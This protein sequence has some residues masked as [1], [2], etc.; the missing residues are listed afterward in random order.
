MTCERNRAVVN[1]RSRDCESNCRRP[2]RGFT[3]SCSKS[4]GR[5]C[6][7]DSVFR[8]SPRDFHRSTS[9]PTWFRTNNW[10]NVKCFEGY[11]AWNVCLKHPWKTLRVVDRKRTLR[12]EN[13]CLIVCGRPNWR[14]W[15]AGIEHQKWNFGAF[16]QTFRDQ[17]CL[18]IFFFFWK[19]TKSLLTY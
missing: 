16:A 11:L 15:R 19:T 18:L 12:N 2:R 14:P 9:I 7:Y 8:L 5:I 4:H 10:Y 6:S 1:T 17:S 13:H 3:L